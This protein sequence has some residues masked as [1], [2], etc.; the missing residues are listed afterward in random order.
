[1]SID[2]LLEAVDQLNPDELRQLQ[3]RITARRQ[4]MSPDE[5]F[6]TLQKAFADIREGLSEEE[7]QDMVDAMNHE[8][9][10]PVDDDLWRD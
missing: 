5:V 8:Y 3:Q 9:I 4:Q 10:E 6:A 2:D 1:M 7:L